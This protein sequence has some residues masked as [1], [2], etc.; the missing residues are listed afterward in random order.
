[1]DNQYLV[2]NV[3]FSEYWFGFRQKQE[4]SIIDHMY[5]PSRY[6]L[7]IVNKWAIS[8]EERSIQ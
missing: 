7:I 8:S 1:M 6:S 4:A 3:Q 2:L 5:K